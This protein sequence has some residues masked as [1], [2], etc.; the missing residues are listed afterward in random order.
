MTGIGDAPSGAIMIASQGFGTE[1]LRLR[2][3]CQRL[4]VWRG[5]RT[6]TGA[7]TLPYTAITLLLSQDGFYLPANYGSPEFIVGIA[8]FDGKGKFTQVDYPADGLRSMGLT[9]FRTGQTGTYA[10]S[11]DCTGL[12]ELDL[13]VGGVGTGHGVIKLAFVVSNGGRSVHAVVSESTSPFATQPG[14][15]QVRTDFWKVGSEQEN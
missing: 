9:D 8:Q 3:L 4:A 5:R 11:R 10:V 1:C 14:I 13:N 15:S 6:M 12:G 7:R 2:S